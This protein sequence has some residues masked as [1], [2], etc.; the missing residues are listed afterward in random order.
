MSFMGSGSSIE[1]RAPS[2]MMISF[3]PHGAR[4]PRGA[5]GLSSAPGLLAPRAA[6]ARVGGRVSSSPVLAAVALY[7]FY[8]V[9]SVLGSLV[10]GL[11]ACPTRRLRRVLKRPAFRVLFKAQITIPTRSLRRRRPKDPH[12]KNLELQN[13]KPP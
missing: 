3:A 2:G 12:D 9:Q 6:T 1:K 4:P 10:C 7:V 11:N 13:A 8:D 5:F